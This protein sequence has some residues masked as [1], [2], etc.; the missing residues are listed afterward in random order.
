MSCLIDDLLAF[1]GHL[2]S[3]QYDTDKKIDYGIACFYIVAGRAR[4]SAYVRSRPR[5]DWLPGYPGRV[6]ATTTTMSTTIRFS[7]L[8]HTI[9]IAFAY[10]VLLY[11]PSCCVCRLPT[12]I[13]EPLVAVSQT[14]PRCTFSLSPWP[15]ASACSLPALVRVVFAVSQSTRV[16]AA[17]RLNDPSTTRGQN[18]RRPISFLFSFPFFYYI[19]FNI[20]I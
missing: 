9:I 6:L 15:F 5:R 17:D 2:V 13:V 10:Y 4:A 14:I 1:F 7:V 18:R 16:A 8:Y 11:T 3:L 12:A 19:T 20:I